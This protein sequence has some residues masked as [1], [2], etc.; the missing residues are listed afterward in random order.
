MD[1]QYILDAVVLLIIGWFFYRLSGSIGA[2]EKNAKDRIDEAKG[3]IK[4]C[5]E[6]VEEELKGITKR[7]DGDIRELRQTVLFSDVFKQHE[8]LEDIRYKALQ[9]LQDTTQK[10]LDVINTKL[11]N[12][13]KLMISA[14]K[15][16]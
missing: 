9:Q 13:V 5:K 1:H 4:I 12:I 6:D 14:S 10:Q 15:K 11:D 3:A 16:Q 8:K 2:I 7:I